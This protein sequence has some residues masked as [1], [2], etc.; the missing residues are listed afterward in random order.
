MAASESSERSAIDIPCGKRESES[1]GAGVVQRDGARRAEKELGR[2]DANA[3]RLEIWPCALGDDRDKAPVSIA[4]IEDIASP[5]SSLRVQLGGGGVERVLERE[6]FQTRNSR[7]VLTPKPNCG[8]P[9]ISRL[10]VTAD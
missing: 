1:C 10:P 4:G 7:D 2:M 9:K 6:G 5:A 3:I 8:G